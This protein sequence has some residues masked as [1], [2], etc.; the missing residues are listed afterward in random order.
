MNYQSKETR[1]RRARELR[2][3]GFNVQVGSMRNQ[4][5]SPDYVQD[6]TGAKFPNGFGGSAR[7]WFDVIYTLEVTR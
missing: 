1:D 4:S 5:L 7:E 3:D 2:E 6:Y